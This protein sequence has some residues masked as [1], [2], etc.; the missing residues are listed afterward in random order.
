MSE[1]NEKPRVDIIPPS[2]GRDAGRQSFLAGYLKKV[3]KITLFMAIIGCCFMMFAAYMI[4]STFNR[5]LSAVSE[6]MVT[7]SPSK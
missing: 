3:G 6:P 5:V 2:F 4:Y 7:T 1:P